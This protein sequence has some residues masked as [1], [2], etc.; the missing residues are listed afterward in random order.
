MTTKTPAAKYQSV[1]LDGKYSDHLQGIAVDGDGVIFASLTHVLAKFD[2]CGKY[3]GEPQHVQYHH[4]DLTYHDGKLFVA[5]NRGGFNGEA[6]ADSWIYVYDATTLQ[7]C[8]EP[9]PVQQVTYGAGG[10]AYHDDRFLVVGGLR[11]GET[12]NLV[13]EFDY[14]F[15]SCA[16][17]E[18]DTGWTSDGI[19]TVCFAEDHWWFGTYGREVPSPPE[20]TPEL[21]KLSAQFKDVRSFPGA[22]GQYGLT[23][24]P[25]GQFLVGF[26]GGD[27]PNQ[28][29]WVILAE[30][31]QYSGL[32][33]LDANTH[34]PKIH[35]DHIRHRVCNRT[36]ACC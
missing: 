33:L 15:R 5:V 14:E 1:T 19:Q 11:I 16:P 20:R 13:Y 9:Y 26:S 21:I 34:N 3:I 25:N 36:S 8:G 10:I 35:Q 31:D 7:L 29:S 18:L 32:R 17:R 24:L 22:P 4:G 30:S 27:S 23:A 12:K 28:I 2:T 6:P